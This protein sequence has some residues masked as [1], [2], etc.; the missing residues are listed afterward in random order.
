MTTGI[1]GLKE[2]QRINLRDCF[3][4]K[5]LKNIRREIPGQTFSLLYQRTKTP[6]VS[7]IGA[8]RSLSS[9][10]VCFRELAR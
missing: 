6:M 1:K 7:K 2:E 4:T 8:L 3:F 5:L 9:E 10:R